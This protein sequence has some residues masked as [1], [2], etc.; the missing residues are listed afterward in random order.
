MSVLQACP[1]WL[2]SLWILFS[3]HHPPP[4]Y[5]ASLKP[6]SQ[7]SHLKMRRKC[8]GENMQSC[9]CVSK[10]KKIANLHLV[11]R[12]RG[13]RWKSDKTCCWFLFSPTQPPTEFG[14]NWI[15]VTPAPA[16][17][18]TSHHWPTLHLLID[19]AGSYTG[20]ENWNFDKS[21]LRN[22][23]DWSCP[24]LRGCNIIHAQQYKILEV[25]GPYGPDF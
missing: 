16:P 6:S 24:T 23:T 10:K 11:N 13:R 14:R 18:P 22:S 2:F 8:E 20:I 21:D 9:K 1:R 7:R 12:K 17:A 5:K 15:W 4:G 19:P 25:Y 3:L